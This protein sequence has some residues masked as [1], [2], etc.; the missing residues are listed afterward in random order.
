MTEL[1]AIIIFVVLLLMI[2]CAF[3]GMDFSEPKHKVQPLD[4]KTAHNKVFGGKNE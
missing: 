2:A 3:G 4:L 1:P